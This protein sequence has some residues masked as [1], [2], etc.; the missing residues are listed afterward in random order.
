MMVTSQI[1]LLFVKTRVRLIVCQCHYIIFSSLAGSIIFATKLT[2][3][4]S[5]LVSM[6]LAEEVEKLSPSYSTSAR[7][8][9]RAGKE[10][11]DTHRAL[12]MG[13]SASPEKLEKLK[14]TPQVKRL[15]AKAINNIFIFGI[16]FFRCFSKRKLLKTVCGDGC[17]NVTMMQVKLETGITETM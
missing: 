17:E 8:T 11:I 7:M 2:L 1:V 4:F 14:S 10:Y 6:T 16:A 3:F 9:S 13:K 5:G 15:L 12:T